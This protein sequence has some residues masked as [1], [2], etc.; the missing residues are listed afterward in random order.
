MSTS[1]VSTSRSNTANQL[2]NA[3]ASPLRSKRRRSFC[4]STWVTS[5]PDASAL[6]LILDAEGWMACVQY[7]A[8][9]AAA[10][11]LSQQQLLLVI[12]FVLITTDQVAIAS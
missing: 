12:P 7:A 1:K 8:A 10:N 3:S 5:S 9:A 6:S 2:S 11:L 4:T